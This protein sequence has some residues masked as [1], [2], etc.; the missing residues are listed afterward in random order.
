MPSR[1]IQLQDG[2]LVEIEAGKPQPRELSGS[3]ADRVKAHW[4]QIN[5]ILRNVIKGFSE[6]W[7][8]LNQDMEIEKAKVELG[9][10]F[11]GEGNIYLAKAT[12]GA[13]LVVKLTLKPKEK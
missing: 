5:P 9:L 13:N 1:L 2:T 11:E 7:D 4:D 10:S 8:E 6:V 3:T 12:L